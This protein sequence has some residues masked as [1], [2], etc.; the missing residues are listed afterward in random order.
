[1]GMQHVVYWTSDVK[2]ITAL[3]TS[4]AA[5]SLSKVCTIYTYNGPTGQLDV[6][7]VNIH[8]EG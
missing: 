2:S 6:H 3:C 8:P 4:S 5:D 7:V 1:M